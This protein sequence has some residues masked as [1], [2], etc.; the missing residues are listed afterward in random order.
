VRAD[1]FIRQAL[2]V[3][4]GARLLPSG[5]C[6]ACRE[7]PGRYSD[8]LGLVLCDDCWRPRFYRPRLPHHREGR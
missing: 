6:E 8:Q 1:D 4:P 7:R 3:F 2:E 5:F